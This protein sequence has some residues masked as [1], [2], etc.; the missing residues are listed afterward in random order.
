M[1]GSATPA[2]PGLVGGEET[3]GPTPAPAPDPRRDLPAGG[4]RRHETAAFVLAGAALLFVFHTHLVPALVAG[5]LTHLVLARTARVLKG[6]RLSHGAARVVALALVVVLSAGVAATAALG[7]F[8]FVRGH[9]GDLPGL[10]AKLADV[11]DRAR[12]QLESLGFSLQALASV[13]NADQL[14]TALSTWLREHAAELTHAGGLAGRVALHVLMGVLASVLVFLRHAP[15]EPRPLAAA[16]AGRVRRFAEAF[17]RVVLAQVE[18]SLV[19]TV[20][21]ALYL[22]ALLPALGFRLPLAGTLV[23]VT[24][25]AG[26]LP[27]VG[28]LVSNSVIVVI[29]F[30]VAP[31]LALV[32]LGFLVGVHKLEYVVNARIVGNRIGAQAWEIF[33]A[34]VV[35]EVAF[36]VPGVVLAPIVYAYVKGELRDRGL[37]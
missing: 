26:L 19:N 27:V 2:G 7:L 11:V 23:L 30:G 9:L 8:A 1:T 22:F 14:R 18:I 12:S 15:P 32:S 29:S 10:F 28:N 5:L 24:F 21:T 3:A 31:W 17:D 25:F 4:D 36:G 16:M 37:V 35:F 6:P 34:I 13:G 20:L 33:L